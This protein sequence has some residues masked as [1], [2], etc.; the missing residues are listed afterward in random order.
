MAK[1]ERIGFYG[2]FTAPALDTSGADKMRALAG[3]GR[4]ITDTT[5][6]VFRAI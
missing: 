3:L 6:W 1:Q 2:K 4:A 5:G